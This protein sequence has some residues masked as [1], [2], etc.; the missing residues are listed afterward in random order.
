VNFDFQIF[1]SPYIYL[2]LK[3]FRKSDKNAKPKLN[4]ESLLVQQ[5]EAHEEGGQQ[6]SQSNL[7][8]N[9]RH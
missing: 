5:K 2:L 7:L 9:E 6:Q 1:S 8:T 4:S 3:C